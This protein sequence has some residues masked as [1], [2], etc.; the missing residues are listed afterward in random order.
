MMD[1]YVKRI[2]DETPL[3]EQPLVVADMGCGDGTLLKTIY[4]YVKAHTERGR[5]LDDYPLTMCGIDFNDSSLHETGVT[6]TAAAVPHGLMSGDIGDPIPMQ[7]ALEARFGVT[8]DQV[9]HVRSF[10]DHDRPFIAPAKPSEPLIERALDAAS[11]A[12]YVDNGSSG[13]LISPS[14][15]FYSLVEHWERWAACLGSHGLL[16]LEVSNLDVVSTYEY[17]PRR[18]PLL[19]GS[20]EAHIP[21]IH[22]YDGGHL[23]QVHARGH[24]FALRLGAGSLGADAHARGPLLTRRGNR[25]PAARRGPPHLPQGLRVSPPAQPLCVC[26]E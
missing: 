19:S 16:V 24:L 26:D 2:F 15:A 3:P 6:L 12:A 18:A 23:W 17:T 1:V 9:L 14:R 5:R 8:R 13:E 25:G 22:T 21:H 7:A 4:L 11:D 20:A 10:L